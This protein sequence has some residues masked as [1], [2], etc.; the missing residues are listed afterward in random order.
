[1]ATVD[2]DGS[3]L[4]VRLSPLEKLGSLHGDLRIPLATVTEVRVSEQPWSELRGM[5]APGT[6]LPGVISLCTRRG[7]GIKDFAAV[8]RRGPAVVIETDG[9]GFDRIVLSREDAPEVARRVRRATT[10]AEANAG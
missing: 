5:R 8:Y 9:G 2:V 4:V 7:V 10:L 6:G 3:Y 1:M